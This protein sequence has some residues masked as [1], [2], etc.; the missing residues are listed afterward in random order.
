[1]TVGVVVGNPKFRSRTWAAA[2][3]LAELLTDAEPDVVID[4]VDLGPALLDPADPRLDEAVTAVTQSDLLIVASPTYK[5]SYTGMLK[6]FLD[7]LPAGALRGTTAVP[8]MLG[9]HWRHGMAA[10]LLLKPV[11]VELGATCPTAGLYV[12]DTEGV[13]SPTGTAWLESARDQLRVAT[14]ATR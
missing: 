3:R 9:A 14:A 10:D 12:L 1:M 6:V 5:G 4:L 2:R 13:D 11:L 8:L 7:A